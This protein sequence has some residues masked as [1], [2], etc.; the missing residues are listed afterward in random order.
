M[1]QQSG[2]QA[3]W[4]R[5]MNDIQPEIFKYRAAKSL[6][7][8][9]WV[10]RLYETSGGA[11]MLDGEYT[12]FGQLISGFDVLDKIAATPTNPNDDRP[13]QD[14]KIIRCTILP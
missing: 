12:V 7:Y 3:G 8:P 9:E 13:Q 6:N 1:F 4:A 5:M 2:D 11:P 10:Q 14:V